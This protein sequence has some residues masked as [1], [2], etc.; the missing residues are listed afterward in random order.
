[1]IFPDLPKQHR[2]FHVLPQAPVIVEEH[3]EPQAITA[4][5][6]FEKHFPQESVPKLQRT[7]TPRFAEDPRGW[8]EFIIL[9]MFL[10]GWVA[11]WKMHQ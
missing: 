8:T 1:M 11:F 3:V 4:E 10:I 9:V 6:W 2:F 5:A 7:K